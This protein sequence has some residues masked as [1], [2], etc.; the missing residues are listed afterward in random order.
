MPTPAAG[1]CRGQVA[2]AG[3]MGAMA[4]SKAPRSPVSVCAHRACA[5]DDTACVECRCARG[6]AR[7][8]AALPEAG[9]VGAASRSALAACGPRTAG[10]SSGGARTSFFRC[11]WTMPAR[12][13]HE[14]T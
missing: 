8:V 12:A 6:A 9:S 7:L 4:L 5:R 1:Y 3:L 11:V 10:R 13:A 14:T 2:Y